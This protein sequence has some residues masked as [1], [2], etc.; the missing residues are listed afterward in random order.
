MMIDLIPPLSEDRLREI[1]LEH[2]P[3][4]SG[5]DLRCC[6][7]S[8]DGITGYEPWPC[9]TARLVA[10]VLRARDELHHT[11]AGTP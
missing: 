11:H 1:W 3:C 7:C 5:P 9:D 4:D 8:D 6:G 10:N 2:Q